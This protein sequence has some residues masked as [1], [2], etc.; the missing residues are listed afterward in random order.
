[1]LDG[2]TRFLPGL[3]STIKN[4]NGPVP[5]QACQPPSPTSPDTSLSVIKNDRRILGQA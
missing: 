3:Q 1:M 5:E 2:A 4:S